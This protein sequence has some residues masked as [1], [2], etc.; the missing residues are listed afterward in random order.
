[1]TVA[2]VVIV[3][4]PEMALTRADGELVLRRVAQAAWSGGAMPAVVV[5]SQTP[6]ELRQAVA[7]LAVTL[8]CPTPGEPQG[9]AWFVHGMRTAAAAVTETSAA[10]LW[11]FKFAWVD[12][13]TVT[14]LVEAHGAA[15]E[16]IVRPAY[17]G[18]PGFPI[19]VPVSLVGRLAELSGQH[20]EEAIAALVAAGV[21]I[22]HI[23]LG[24]PGIVHDMA[25]PR[26]DLP[27]Y[28]GPPQPAGSPPP[29]WN[30]ALAAQASDTPG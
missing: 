21:P 7:D 5:A 28:Q 6:Q 30:A 26:S 3:P 15:P 18:Q 16:A 20:G 23:E 22:R 1:M 11:P 14:S 8:T 25:T 9:I 19:L 4:D 13:E 27:D 24:D 17:G 10:L 2:A 12:P 29:E